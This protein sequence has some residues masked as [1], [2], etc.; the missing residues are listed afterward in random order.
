MSVNLFAQFFY[1][2]KLIVKLGGTQLQNNS[3]TGTQQQK[4]WELLQY[5]DHHFFQFLPTGTLRLAIAEALLLFTGG[6]HI[7]SS[8]RLNHPTGTIAMVALALFVAKNSTMAKFIIILLS[9]IPNTYV[10]MRVT[11]ATTAKQFLQHTRQQKTI[12]QEYYY[13]PYHG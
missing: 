6:H 7:L 13:V 11:Y 5:S 4:G 12:T 8:S 9:N 2:Q 10:R 3:I 1:G